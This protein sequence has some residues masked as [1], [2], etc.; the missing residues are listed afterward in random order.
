MTYY[1]IMHKQITDWGES[2]ETSSISRPKYFTNDMN[3]S[4]CLLFYMD[5]QRD[6]V[7][8]TRDTKISILG[9]ATSG[10]RLSEG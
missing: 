1:V 4:I 2:M 3:T 7:E 10:V 8:D 5:A 6:V 9:R